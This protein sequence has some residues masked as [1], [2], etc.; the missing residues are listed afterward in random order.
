MKFK[1]FILMFC[2]VLLVNTVSA[3]EWDNFKTYDEESKTATI[4]N[5]L[6]FGTKIAEVQLKTPLDLKVARGYQ[7]VAEFEIKGFTDYP[8]A[9]KELELYDKHYSLS[10]HRIFRSYDYKYKTYVNVSVDER[11]CINQA[12]DDTCL[13]YGV[14]GSHYEVQEKWIKLTPADIKKNDVLTIGIFTNVEVGDKI[15]WIPNLFG[16]R[17]DEWAIWTESLN[18]DLISYYKLDE[19]VNGTV[20][21]SV[22]NHNGSNVEAVVNISGKINTAYQFV[23]NDYIDLQS[24]TVVNTSSNF[25]IYMWVNMTSKTDDG[26]L[27]SNGDNTNGFY[28]YNIGSGGWFTARFGT[29]NLF[30]G[31]DPG[32]T[33]NVYSSVIIIYDGINYTLIIDNI[34][35][36]RE[37]A[38]G[39]E[40]NDNFWIGNSVIAGTDFHGGL[41]ETGIWGR[42]ITY[43]DV[44]VG[45]NVT[46]EAAQLD[47]EG[48]GISWTDVF[49][50]VITLNSPVDNFNSSNV[51][52]DF[53]GTVASSVTLTN[54]SLIIND[55][56][57]ETN[58]SGINNTNYLFTSTLVEGTHNW[59]YEACNTDFCVNATERS[60]TLDTTSPVITITSPINNISYF[61]SGSN[62][63]LNWTV[64]DT[65]LDSCWYN[66]NGTNVS[67]TCSDN[68]TNINVTDHT[69]IDLTF[70]ANDSVENLGS[71]QTNWS[72]DIFEH[73][74]IYNSET[75]EGSSEEFILNISKNSSRQVSTANLIYNLI[76]NEGSFTSG[77]DLNIS[78]TISVP[79]VDADTNISF[80][81]SITLDNGQIINTT[82]NN[83]TVFQ[84]NMDDCS[85]FTTTLYNY[86]LLKEEEQTNLTGNNSIEL[87]INL[88]DSARTTNIINFSKDYSSNP[89]LVCI[90]V[91]LTGS[92][93]FSIDSVAK[94]SADDYAVEY[95]NIRDFT[96]SEDSIYQN[97]SLFDL[98]LADAT[99]FRITFKGEEFLAVEGALVFIQRQYIAENGTFKTVELPITDSNGQTIVHLVEK[100]VVYNILVTN[101]TNGE[102]LGIFNNLL[103]FCE[104]ATIGDCQINLN[105]LSTA[106]QIFNYNNELKIGVTTPLF[107]QTNR[108]LSFDFYTFDGSTKKVELISN[109]T[110][111]L[112]N[113]SACDNSLTS[114]SGTL[115]C[116]IPTALGNSSI[117]IYVYVDNELIF[118]DFISLD[119]AGYGDEGIFFVFLIVLAL[120]IIFSESK[121]LMLVGGAVGLMA[122]VGLS[123]MQGR[124]LGV[125]SSIIW[126]LVVIGVALWKL[127]KS[128][129]D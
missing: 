65:L 127:N 60:I 1:I 64:S 112:G 108:L 77:D 38:I 102:I 111:I 48:L 22:G 118:Q 6:K 123:L 81:F 117:S 4:R 116:T 126:I 115:S 85:G 59:T 47:N 109:K 8:N 36:Q 28:L 9:L 61:V 40:G 39:V 101:G 71:F 45:Q 24:T 124:I 78:E 74:L 125:T 31:S 52:I 43:G 76:S 103:A 96:L 66:Y 25:S 41:D 128:K 86:T 33:N 87:D 12:V 20:V 15:E 91:N 104:D 50:P 93:N 75:I 106:T 121:S 62:L 83:Q 97:I 119:S 14:V 79:N 35:K 10:E 82:S 16:V 44:A 113:T 5:G 46:G 92:T 7:K 57:T 21:D 88:F 11:A 54:V 68:Q 29:V 100:D 80:Y 58:N 51:T 63:S 26:M 90:N 3:I 89:A 23:S 114:S 107:N 84:L 13:E 2:M 129:P 32:F 73:Y 105:A 55:T 56:Y 70:Y 27:I 49:P 67:V 72:Y 53:N 99:D 34:L 120:A 17:V 95:Y 37:A 42:A 18:T 110:D 98:A 94:Y 30:Y 122:G 69:I 19:A